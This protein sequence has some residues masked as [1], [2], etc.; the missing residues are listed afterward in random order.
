MKLLPTFVLCFLVSVSL[1]YCSTFGTVSRSYNYSKQ[2]IWSAMSA[3]IQKNYGGVKKVN[4]SPPTI[5][6]NLVVKDKKFGID[7]TAY[8]VFAGLSGFSRPYVVDVEIRAYPTGEESS[9]YSI[10]RDK[11]QEVIDQIGIL[12]EHRKYNSSLQDQ[13]QPY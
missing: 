10:D 12:L 4:P 8:Q 6:S 5:V 9:D 2:E 3:V 1:N 11:A 13:F 7:K